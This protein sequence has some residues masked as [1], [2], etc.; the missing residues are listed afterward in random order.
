LPYLLEWDRRYRDH[1]LVI[2]GIHSP[3]YDFSSDPQNVFRAVRRLGV[4]YPVAV[5]SHLRIA[6]AYGNNYWPRKF[7]IDA[8]GR[9]R[10]DHIGEGAYETT[11]RLI[12]QLLHEIDPE[13]RFP[14]P[15]RLLRPTDDETAACY[16]TTPEL[17]LGWA[18]GRLGNP[19]TSKTTAPVPFVLPA[20]RVPDVV[21]AEGVWEIQSEYI[22]HARDTEEYTDFLYLTYRA[23][24]LNVV[25]KPEEVYWMK[26]LVTVDGQPV[27][28]DEAGEDIY[29][30]D[31]GRSYVK[32]DEARMYNL[33]RNQPYAQYELRLYPLGRG[34]SV[35]SFS[36]GTCVIPAEQ[37]RLEV[38]RPKS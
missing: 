22:R 5:D 12:Q 1:G 20:E 14:S 35:Y 21:Y 25:M 19:P 15:M 34:L 3:Q 13:I 24:E 7:L 28:R 23:T 9:I 32:V 6:Q 17:Y 8:S 11:E 33:T 38:P 27:R 26:V 4:S 30:E 37:K 29:Y 10:F 36:F 2:I 16:P 18:R 31:D